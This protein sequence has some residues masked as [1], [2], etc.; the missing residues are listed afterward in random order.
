MKFKVYV[1]YDEMRSKVVIIGVIAALFAGAVLGWSVSENKATRISDKQVE[2]K[3]T[4]RRL[5]LEHNIWY[6]LHRTAIFFKDEKNLPYIVSR[7]DKNARELG[8]V[9]KPF[10][11][12]DAGNEFMTL[13]REHNRLATKEVFAAMQ[14]KN[15]GAFESAREKWYDNA[16]EIATL[17]TTINPYLPKDFMKESIAAHYGISI[18]EGFNILSQTSIDASDFDRNNEVMLRTADILSEGIIKQF[19]NKFYPL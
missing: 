2:L 15:E 8:D 16:D 13:I 6:R 9:L 4:M 11:G 19:P 14:S 18:V 12:E 3:M 17:L 7:V 5:W 10:Y 1:K